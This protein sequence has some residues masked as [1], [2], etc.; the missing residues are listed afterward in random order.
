LILTNVKKHKLNCDKSTFSKQKLFGSVLSMINPV[1]CY[2]PKNGYQRVKTPLI[3]MFMLK[4]LK[5][6]LLLLI[7]LFIPM[8]VSSM[9]KYLKLF[10]M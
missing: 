3:L 5:K 2:S 8:F 7:R 6:K 1:T 9:N 4:R 10:K